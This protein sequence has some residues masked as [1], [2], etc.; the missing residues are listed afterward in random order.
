MSVAFHSLAPL[1]SQLSS[2]VD[3]QIFVAMCSPARDMTAGYHAVRFLGWRQG[4][5]NIISLVGALI[6][7]RS[8]VSAADKTSIVS[9]FTLFRG[10]VIATTDENESIVT[11]FIG[12]GSSDLQTLSLHAYSSRSR[13]SRQGASWDPCHGAEEV[14]RIS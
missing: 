4:S 2:A 1:M 5:A 14:R 6:D 10:V 11:A 12:A 8:N 9:R 13:G 7:H 3:N